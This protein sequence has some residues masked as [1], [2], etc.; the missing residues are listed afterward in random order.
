MKKD[1]IALT[2]FTSKELEG[3]IL[4]AEKMK[5][6]PDKYRKS[7]QG[8]TLGMIF[9]KHSTRTR[10]SFEVGIFQLG[11]I[12]LYFGPGQLQLDRGESVSDTAKTLS[13]YL[14]GIMIRTFSHKDVE[15]LAKHAT[16]PVINGLTDFNHPC[17]IMA[18]ILTIKEKFKKL[19]GL[20]LV[21]LGDGNNVAT[22]LLFGC[23]K[24]GIDITII[25]PKDYSLSP[26][27]VKTIETEAKEKG[28]KILLTDNVKEGVLGANIVY[29]DTWA[30]MGQEEEKLRRQE[31]FRPFAV[32]EKV[33][34]SADKNAIFMHCLP[35]YRGS[36]VSQSVIDGPQSVV[37]DEAENRLHAQK[38]IMYTLMK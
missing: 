34:S 18:D 13:R 28:V 31:I 25:S 14:D 32:N 11:G 19:K 3:M 38:A 24:M 2:D 10:V 15:E 5:K 36:E 9:N 16:V 30:S 6:N 12:G 22:S 27:I 37:F 20:K 8:K 35:A 26:K 23:V 1:F 7:L 17:Q 29:T 4:L 21:Y 33:M